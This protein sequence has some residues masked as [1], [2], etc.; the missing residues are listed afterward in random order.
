MCN[1]HTLIPL[2]LMG[3]GQCDLCHYIS[4]K[5]RLGHQSIESTGHALLLDTPKCTLKTQRKTNNSF[6]CESWLLC[7][8]AHFFYSGYSGEHC[9][10]FSRHWHWKEPD[11][12][13][14]FFLYFLKLPRCQILQLLPPSSNFLIVT[15]FATM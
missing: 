2:L 8:I 13:F 15:L 10:C 9:C 14:P 5:L 7:I 11:E 4:D 3:L 6:W 1:G 12:A